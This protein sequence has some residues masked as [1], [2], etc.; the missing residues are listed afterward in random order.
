MERERLEKAFELS[1][2]FRY[3][4]ALEEFRKIAE[5][6]E[7]PLTKAWALLMTSDVLV[8]MSENKRA[9]QALKD[10]RTVLDFVGVSSDRDLVEQ[11]RLTYMAE[12]QE[13]EI[14]NAGGNREEALE[15]YKSFLK[16]GKDERE[17]LLFSDAYEHAEGEIAI[18]LADFNRPSEALPILEKLER[19]RPLNAVL[20]FY[21]GSCQCVLDQPG[22]AVAKLEESR[23]LGLP[24]NLNFRA[25]CYLGMA[26]YLLQDYSSA[27]RELE[28]GAR[29]ATP[30]YIKEV[31]IWKWLEWSC[32]G[33][34]L[35]A[36]AE[37]YGRMAR[38]SS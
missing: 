5:T 2:A 15:R 28:L 6:T 29:T 33:L 8:Q 36:E 24:P 3:A 25:H 34:G 7:D 37:E 19:V 38:P 35:K 26:Y 32:V 16:R 13:I 12:L 14:I 23:R 18:L 4:E 20:E 1:T 30:R 10:A 17:R 11:R 22:K 27:K 21:L 9:E 31:E